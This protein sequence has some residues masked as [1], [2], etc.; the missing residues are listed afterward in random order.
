MTEIKQ[1]DA[2]LDQ[3]YELRLK[4][5]FEEGY[6]FLLRSIELGNADAMF[7]L[8]YTYREGGWGLEPNERL[9]ASWM[10][11]SCNAGSDVAA[12][13]LTL[14]LMNPMNEEQTYKPYGEIVWEHTNPE[15]SGKSARDFYGKIKEPFARGL[16][17]REYW[18]KERNIDHRII[19]NLE[20]SALSKSRN[21]IYAQ[22]TLG[23]YYD[24]YNSNGFTSAYSNRVK[25]NYWMKKAADN[26]FAPAQARYYSDFPFNQKY[27]IPKK[28]SM[29]RYVCRQGVAFQY[30]HLELLLKTSVFDRREETMW[31]I[32]R[33][34]YEIKNDHD[35]IDSDDEDYSGPEQFVKLSSKISKM[36]VIAR[37]QNLPD[38]SDSD[39]SILK[40]TNELRQLYIYAKSTIEGRPLVDSIKWKNQ[41]DKDHC[42][43]VFERSNHHAYRATISLLVLK[44]RKLFGLSKDMTLVLAKLVWETRTDPIIWLEIDD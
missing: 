36:K 40:I 5:N 30:G 9:V 12:A 38:S 35:P 26:G 27:D 6:K 44:K 22:Y 29:A 25:S 1:G 20:T 16:F 2:E 4:G 17:L 13:F 21:R 18:W 33:L 10:V 19:K 43:K 7:E 32:K 24:P 15:A 41:S 37:K 8:A 34:E 23:R 28:I 11:K 42:C 39:K 3:A 14:P 31:K